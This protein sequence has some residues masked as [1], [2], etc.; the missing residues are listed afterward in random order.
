MFRRGSQSC[1]THGHLVLFLDVRPVFLSSSPFSVATSIGN[2]L[3]CK[4]ITNAAEVL[5][6]STATDFRIVWAERGSQQSDPCQSLLRSKKRCRKRSACLDGCS[7]IK[8]T[9]LTS[10]RSVMCDLRWLSFTKGNICK[11]A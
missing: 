4:L 9:S 11:N 6:R 5:C 10:C 7:A 3:T 2:K 1:I 8:H